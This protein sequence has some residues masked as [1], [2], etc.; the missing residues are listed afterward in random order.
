[1]SSQNNKPNC[2]NCGNVL[3]SKGYGRKGKRRFVCKICNKWFTFNIDGS[4]CTK[5]ENERMDVR[6]SY[7]IDET[8]NAAEISTVTSTRIKNEKDLIKVCEIDTE[9]WEIER[10]VCNKWEVGRKEVSKDI[11]YSNINGKTVKDGTEYD[12][13]K[14][15]VE[16]L[17]QVKVWLKKK[18]K[19]LIL[20]DIKEETIQEMK[21][22]SP[23]YP[24]ITYLKIKDKFLL[25]PDM[26][27]LHYGKL[28]WNEE[29]GEDFDIKIAE[30]FALDCL[31]SLIN[32]S[33]VYSIDRIL[34]P[35]GNDYFNVNDKTNTTV[36]NTPQQEDTRWQKTFKKGRE[37]AV[38][39][40]DMLSVIAPVDVLIVPGNHDEERTFY[41]GDALECWYHNNPNVN[42][43]NKA[44]KRK[45][46]LYGKNLIGFTHGYYEK[47][48]KLPLLMS[49]EQPDWWAMSKFR[50]WQTGD[51]HYKKEI[52]TSLKEDESQGVI[53]RI[54]RSLT[55]ND[56]WL[57]DKGYVGP[58]RAA[59][60]FVRH[61]EKGLIAQ[62]TAN[63]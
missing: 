46:Y 34:F 57:F 4:L 54:L 36:H 3:I 40:I 14:I 56:A 55:A 21:K 26:P 18:V 28:A 61:F 63:I 52:R 62:F 31:S 51:K 24:K 27:D 41:M 43:N 2:P 19:E 30:E 9:V 1:M 20:K 10:W 13:G 6:K 25:E 49:L 15:F 29:S 48:D 35:I 45:Y 37:L 53:V 33:S 17:F 50:E 11:S 5:I 47:L 42:V 23:K 7:S 12:S 39:M 22:F 38:K 59:E 16:P 8:K 32:Q 58:L 44:I 60:A